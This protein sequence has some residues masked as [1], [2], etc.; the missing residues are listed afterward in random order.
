MKKISTV[1]IL[2]AGIEPQNAKTN[3]AQPEM[4]LKE[5]TQLVR[6]FLL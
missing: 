4:T 5:N 6:L 3:W 2:P 1:T